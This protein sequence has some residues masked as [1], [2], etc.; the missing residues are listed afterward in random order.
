MGSGTSRP[1]TPPIGDLIDYEETPH[2]GPGRAL[3]ILGSKTEADLFDAL[4]EVYRRAVSYGCY[5]RLARAREGLILY[6]YPPRPGR[7]RA[8]LG[9]VLAAATLLT[10]YVS[11]VALAEESRGFAWTPLG[12]LLG[13]L[14][15]LI[16]HELGHLSMMKRYGVPSSMPY[17]LPAPPLQLGFIGTFGAVIN[18]RWLPARNRHLALIGVMGPIAGFLA[19]LPVAWYGMASSVI[20]PATGTGALPLAPLVFLLIPPPGTPGPG[21]VI[22]LSPMAFSAYIVFFVTFLNLVPVAMLDGGHV[23]RSL[24][25]LRGHQIVSQAVIASLLAASLVY[26]GLMLFTLLVLGLHAM[27]QGYHP[28]T[29]LSDEEVDPATAAAAVAFGILLVLTLPVPV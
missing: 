11:G 7:S 26:P 4:E 9:A 22:V 17:L 23:V 8:L 12:Y 10:V 29:A 21:E 25:G 16:I 19:A 28:G 2:G 14:G 13:L 18:M 27:S 6:L 20:E 24:L 1:C 5:P 15:P 3:L